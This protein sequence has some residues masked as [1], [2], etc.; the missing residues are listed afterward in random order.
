MKLQSSRSPKAEITRPLRPLLFLLLLLCGIALKPSVAQTNVVGQWSAVQTWPFRAIHMAMLPTGKVMFWSR[1]PEAYNPYLWNPS[2]NAL[3]PINGPGYQ[4]FCSSM[5]FLADGRLLIMG[6]HNSADGDGQPFASIYDPFANA[7]TRTPDMTNGRWYPSSVVLPNNDVVVMSGSYGGYTNNDLPQV[8]NGTAWRNLTGARQALPL[9][10]DIFTA[11]NGKVFLLG[12]DQAS[13]YLDTTG[14]GS[15]SF[16]ANRTFPN[17]DYGCYCMYAD[18]KFFYAGGGDPP[19]DTAEVIDLNVATPTWR[20]LASRMVA[21]RRQVNCTLLP[22]GKVLVTGG[23]S[24]EGFND[25]TTPVLQAEIW[26][27]A[28]EQFSRVASMAVG[29]WYH[30]TIALLPDGRLVSAG[31]DGNFN[32][33]IYS[34]PYLFKGTRPTISTVPAAFNYGQAFDVTTPNASAISQ[35]TLLRLT[36][37]THSNNFDQRILRPS[38]VKASGKLTITAPSNPN[39]CPAGYYLLFILDGNGIPSIGKIV[40]IGTLPTI[41]IAPANLTASGSNQRIT[42]NWTASAGATSYTVKR[43]S[44]ATGTFANVATGVNANSY[45]NTG[46]TNGTTYYYVVQSVNS[47]GTSPN[48]NVASATPVA[49]VNGNGTGL[50]GQYFNTRDQSGAVILTRTDPTIAFDWSGSPGAGVNADNFS[51]RWT[52][53]VMP[54]YSETYQFFTTSDDGIR[55]WVNGQQIINNWTDHGATENVGS[56]ALLA[57]QKYDITVE[58]YDAGGGATAKLEWLSSSQAREIVPASQLYPPG[59]GQPPAAP[60]NLAAVKGNGQVVLNWTGSAGATS[61]RVKRSTTNGG[62]YTTI[63]TGIVPL[64]FTDSGLTNG[65]TYYYVVSAVNADGESPNSNQASATP[66]APLTASAVFVRAD[67]AT[68]GNWKGAYGSQGYNVAGDAAFYPVYATV[69]TS[70]VS[71]YT[72][73]GNPSGT[74]PLLRASSTSGRIAAAMYNPTQMDYTLSIT[75]GLT[76]QVSFYCLDFDN[77]G[78]TMRIEVRD[79]TNNALLDSRTVSG[80]NSGIYMVWNI[81]GSVKFQVYNTGGLNAAISGLFFD[82]PGTVDNPPP[83]TNL[84]ATA[85]GSGVNLVW[86]GVGQATSYTVKRS[87]TTGGTYTQIALGLAGTT[88]ADTGVTNGTTYYYVVTANNSKGESLPSNE[89]SATPAAPTGATAIFVRTD[90]TTQGSWKG[91]YGTQ[92]YNVIAD[93]VSYP[94][95]ATVSTSGTSSYTWSSSTSQTQ[96]LQYVNSSDRLAACWYNSTGFDLNVALSS[97]TTRNVALYC[98]DWDNSGRALRIEA[99]DANTNALLAQQNVSA[100]ATG[101]YLVWRISGAVKFSLVNTG[102]QNSVL[103]GVFFDP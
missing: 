64:N 44:S 86:Q 62:A 92:G 25:T 100:F 40:H 77:Q 101:K 1:Y 43:G 84:N 23:V 21:A 67:T 80:F 56:V 71:S 66:S 28:T 58:F 57:G 2:D 19:T 41:P 59:S 32:A 69:S 63:A 8:F 91:V 10:P 48:S 42:L 27:P 96:A 38:F 81:A 90:T 72:W 75:S 53:K 29:R 11:P 60:T 6:G 12:P 14:T 34:P 51:V 45:V 46:L 102:A 88:Y 50:Q 49:P 95:Y 20:Q 97:G 18:G 54:R 93:S 16:V 99:R 78:R 82:A 61:Y 36:S 7:Y 22:D 35:V 52:G 74:P 70:G 26:D 79:L 3:T 73:D 55:V 85:G 30:S 39:L 94:T 89:A 9:Y 47:A 83:P 31:G 103:S 5:N 68:Q 33:E 76:R 24:G 15:W 13:Q 65:T 37:V 98:L 17:R 4:E 87:T